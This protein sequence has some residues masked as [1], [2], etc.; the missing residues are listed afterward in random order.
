M[1]EPGARAAATS[2]AI[3]RVALEL[4]LERGY[5]Q[6]TVDMICEVVGISQRTFFNHF[7][8]KDD[9]LLGLEVPRIDERAARRFVISTGPIL[10]EAMSLVSLPHAV[11]PYLEQRFQVIASA[12]SL[13]TRQMDR[14]GAIEEELRE[15]VALRLEHERPETP[16]AERNDEATMITHLLAGVIR[17]I[18]TSRSGEETDVAEAVERARRV[19][20]RLLANEAESGAAPGVTS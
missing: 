4:A 3:E 1:T 10:V 8:T 11:D 20:R 18:G 19:L 9:A 7:P 15:I 14:I 2:A 13:I 5:E 16:P 6:L 12:P 17:F